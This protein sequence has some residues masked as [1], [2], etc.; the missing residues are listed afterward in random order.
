[1]T[2]F[3]HPGE[4]AKTGGPADS[5]HWSH[6]ISTAH[7]RTHQGYCQ[8]AYWSISVSPK[9]VWIRLWE[10]LFASHINVELDYM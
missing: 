5:R 3:A 4:E 9:D 8:G 10:L 6:V 2:G 1:M 7:S